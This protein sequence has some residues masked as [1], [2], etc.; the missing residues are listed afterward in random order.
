[1]LLVSSTCIFAAFSPLSTKTIDLCTSLGT[2]SCCWIK[3]WDIVHLFVQ[4]L[5]RQ[6]N[7]PFIHLFQNC[8]SFVF[9]ICF[10]SPA[11]KIH[12]NVSYRLSPDSRLSRQREVSEYKKRLQRICFRG[13]MVVSKGKAEESVFWVVFPR[14]ANRCW[15][16]IKWTFLNCHKW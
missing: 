8:F 1:M 13:C 9:V 4:F 15:E 7:V 10:V 12:P 2:L 6:N 16:Y 5:P 11:T 14:A 3:F